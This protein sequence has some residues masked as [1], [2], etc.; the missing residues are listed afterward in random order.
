MLLTGPSLP[1]LAGGAANALVVLLH[2]VGA[3]G[4]DLIDLA[5]YWRPDLAKTAFVSLNAPFPCDFAPDRLQWFSVADRTPAV[6]LQGARV[7]ALSL[8]ATLDA[9]LA[10]RGLT[11]DRLALVGFSQGAMMALHVGL[12]RKRQIAGIV[13]FSGALRGG[14]TLR[15]EIGAKPPVLLVHGEMDEIVPFAAMAEARSALEREGVPVAV[16][17]RPRLGHAIDEAGLDAAGRFLR[18]ALAPATTA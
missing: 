13:A 1:P 15:A 10:A 9:L 17:A 14:E 16:L 2:G 11:D 6:L 7:A 5:A 4:D 18:G 3:N 12:R 8:D